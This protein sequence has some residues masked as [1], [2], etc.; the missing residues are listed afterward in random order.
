MFLGMCLMLLLVLGAE[1]ALVWL[2][3]R[4]MAEHLKENPDAVA[5][6]TVHLFVPLLGRKEAN[7]VKK[8]KNEAVK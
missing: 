1:G 4:R 5:A 7:D 3:W 2:V 6:L 8:L